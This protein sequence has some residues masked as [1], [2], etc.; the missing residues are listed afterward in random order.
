MM[1]IFSDQ[2]AKNKDEWSIG[3]KKVT[4]TGRGMRCYILHLSKSKCPRVTPMHKLIMYMHRAC[5]VRLIPS[6]KDI[7]LSLEW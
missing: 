6:K 5:Y 3:R 2:S 1:T 7:F 4:I